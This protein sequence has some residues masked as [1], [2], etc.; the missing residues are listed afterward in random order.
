MN[1]TKLIS[2]WSMSG[3]SPDVAGRFRSSVDFGEDLTVRSHEEAPVVNTSGVLVKRADA[4]DWA[5]LAAT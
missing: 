4:D 1:T 3:A 2:H 5:P